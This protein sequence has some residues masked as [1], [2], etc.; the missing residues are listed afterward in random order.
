MHWVDQAAEKL[1]KKGESHVVAS[2]TSISG[3]LHIGHTP[4]VFIAESVGR[5]LKERNAEVRV[6]WY[7][8]DVDPMRRIPWPLSVDEYGKYL[9]M[10][11]ID[12]PAPEPGFDNFVEFFKKPFV[13]SLGEFGVDPEVYSSAEVYRNGELKDQIRTAL[14]KADVIRDILDRYRS[15]PLREDW[16]PF[17]PICEECGKI[18][19]TRAYDWEGDYVYYICEGSDYVDGCDHKGKANYVKGE[20]KLTWRVEWPARWTMLRVTCEPFGKDHAADGGSYDTGKLIAR[21]VFDHEPPEPIPYEWISL[22]G[23]PMSSSKGHVFTLPE[24]L[25]VADPELL[26]FFIFRSKALKAK[27]FDPGFPLLE[28][29]QEYRQ[30]EDV[31]F[32]KEEVSESREEQMNRIYELS[33]VDKVPEHYPQRIPIK[34]AVVLVQVARDSDHALEILKKKEILR[35]PDD[36]ELEIAYERLE[37]AENWVEKYAPDQARLEVLDELPKEAKQEL[38]EGQKKSLSTLADILAKGDF[39][40]VEIHNKVFEIARSNE[41]KPVELFQAIYLVLLGQKSGPRVGNFLTAL[42]DEFVIERFKEATS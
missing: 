37:R 15:E 23:E 33:Q 29:Y 22:K 2:G 42:E 14:R 8:D 3:H 35:K 26:R 27:N 30:F 7:T 5:A 34:L 25:E 4:D 31:Y 18:A 19:T 38:S 40:P 17:D 28:L 41:M 16:V 1:I 20:G 36:W 6:V 32:E 39:E 10:P 12:I 21:E 13:D 11:Y 9:G 24:W